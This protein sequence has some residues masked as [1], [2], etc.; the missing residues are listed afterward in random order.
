MIDDHFLLHLEQ[1]LQVLFLVS[2]DIRVGDVAVL[3]R[4][5]PYRRK[6]QD[7]L[8]GRHVHGG[9]EGELVVDPE[10]LLVT[11]G[12][13]PSL[14]VFDLAMRVGLGLEDPLCVQS[15]AARRSLDQEPHA[16]VF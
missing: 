9:H 5:T 3:R 12:D 2:L 16:F 1:Y 10:N 14:Q 15:V 13:Q 7:H 8:H 11:A 4:D 6:R